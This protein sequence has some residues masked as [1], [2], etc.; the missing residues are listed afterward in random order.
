MLACHTD[1]IYFSKP[2]ENSLIFGR[3]INICRVFV[4]VAENQD[5][6]Y[7]NCKLMHETFSNLSSKI[8]L[9]CSAW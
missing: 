9:L 4:R 7:I 2:L 3:R 6:I 1:K 5:A 8:A